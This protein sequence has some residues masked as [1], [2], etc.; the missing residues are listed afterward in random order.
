ML[1]IKK[2]YKNDKIIIFFYFVVNMFVIITSLFQLNNGNIKNFNLTLIT[3]II[4]LLPFILELKLNIKI[5]KTLKIIFLLFIVSSII[6]G[7]I[8]CFYQLIP[9]W[10]N[11]LHFI[12]GFIATM[13]GFSLIKLLN[14]QNDIKK[15][16]TLFLLMFSFSFS[17]TLDI[18]WEL[19]EFFSDKYFNVDMQKDTYI[20]TIK[21][22]K[23]NND[24]KLMTIVY[25]DHTRI[26]DKNN[27]EII[28]ING[29]LDIGL[30]DTMEDMIVTFIASSIAI[31]EI[32]L[33]IKNI[34]KHQY[35][36]FFLISKK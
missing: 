7:E 11:I 6:L 8:Y 32:Y 5:T 28:T 23:L 9:I 31:I 17:I 10:D 22:V 16:S 19:F 21:T 35:L 15:L 12:K 25:I 13:I 14:N 30:N 34:N 20:D 36:E 33:Y 3:M 27:K 1:N 2:Y 24:N 4:I 29:Y 18:S 26:Y